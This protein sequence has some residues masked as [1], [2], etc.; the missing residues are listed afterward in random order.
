MSKPGDW[1]NSPIALKF[2]G[3]ISSTTAH[4]HVQSQSDRGILMSIS[5]L[6]YLKRLEANCLQTA[7]APRGET[8]KWL[9]DPFLRTRSG[10][11]PS[12]RLRPHGGTTEEGNCSS[13]LPRAA[14]AGL[15]GT[16]KDQIH[17]VPQDEFWCIEWMWLD[18]SR[19]Q[20]PGS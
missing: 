14:A 12:S 5:R 3:R 7:T 16:N 18:L 19:V 10:H 11:P 8:E 20:I 2:D 15:N 17:K 9:Q 1:Y 6:Q 4:S 13:L